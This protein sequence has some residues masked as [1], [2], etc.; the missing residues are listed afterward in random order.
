[1]PFSIVRDEL[2]FQVADVVV[3]PANGALRIDGGAGLSVGRVAGLDELQAACDEI[4]GCEVG[5]AVATP[6][7]RF[8]AKALVH[9]VGP[10]WDGSDEARA[11]LAGAYD[12][13][14][15]LAASLDAQS[16]ALPLISAGARGCPAAYSLHVALERVRMFLEEH[17]EVEV[18]IVVFDGEAAAAARSRFADLAS[19]IDDAYAEEHR[20][21]L[22]DAQTNWDF[23]EDSTRVCGA[24]AP[25]RQAAPA[26]AS[27]PAPRV[28]ESIVERVREG[29][30]SAIDAVGDAVESVRR[31]RNQEGAADVAASESAQGTASRSLGEMLDDIDDTFSNTLL[32]IIDE[33]GLTDSFVYNRA[34]ISRQHFSKIRSN[35]SYQPTKKTVIAFAIALE[36]SL[37]ETRDLL[38]RAGFALSHSSRFDLIVE[39]FISQGV[40]DIFT[41]NEALYLYDQPLLA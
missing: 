34:N 19:F 29:V 28:R 35:A 13:A 2:A 5:E 32:R 23:R 18:R 33:R 10:T 37:D 27:A 40:Y 20:E 8:P 24:P 21:Y 25:S 6:A 15:A 17:D 7:F 22:F 3:V 1:M 4:G 16:V 30:G 39:W 31:T 41:I 12:R 38:A 11:E 9:A 26:S 14:L 36:L